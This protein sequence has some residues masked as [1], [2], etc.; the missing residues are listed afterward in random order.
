MRINENEFFRQATLLIL[1]SLDIEKALKSCHRYLN[2]F[3]PVFSIHFSILEPDWSAISLIAHST[4][5]EDIVPR[6]KFFLSEESKAK[7]KE[8][9]A[10]IKT[11]SIINDPTT[12]PVALNSLDLLGRSDLSFLVMHLEIEGKR[13]TELVLQAEGK[14][15]YNKSHAHLLSLLNQPFAIAISNAIRHREVLKLKDMQADQITYLHHE[16]LRFSGDEIIGRECGLK[17]VMEKVSQVASLNTPVL[18]LGETGVGKE[19][20]A[21]AIHYSSKRSSGPFIKINCGAIP[22]TL[23]DSELFGHEKGSFTGAFTKKRGLFELANHGTI[24]LDEIGEL[25]LPAQTRFLRVLQNHEIKRVGGIL[26]IPVDIRIIV[27]T[28][29]NLEE[30][31]I[32]NKFRKDLFFRLNVF[33]IEIP[34]LRE[35]R[36]DITALIHHFLTRKAKEMKIQTIP[37]ISSKAIEMLTSYY[38]PG[39]VRELENMVERALIRHMGRRESGTLILPNM[40]FTG[41]FEIRETENQQMPVKFDEI[42]YHP[43]IFTESKEL[44]DQGVKIKTLDEAL[45]EHI[46]RALNFTKGKITGLGGAAEI[47]A[48]NPNT[49][50][51]KMDKLGIRYKRKKSNGDQYEI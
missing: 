6:G 32:S 11:V 42:K 18:L 2:N 7:Y 48:V 9:L 12:H 8:E 31:V 45:Y 38:W 47:L 19:V 22:E 25:P 28:H 51:G 14:N 26:D 41:S 24:F 20:I 16:L 37:S 1:G 17:T 36:E 44:P 35:R 4:L 5:S 21:N 27:A 50:R 29:R 43:H 30:M 23:V 3:M 13:I 10:N 15:Q 40:G 49:L 39:N 34:P 33:P 46:Q